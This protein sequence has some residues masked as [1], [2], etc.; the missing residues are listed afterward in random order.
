M[1][2]SINKN[3]SKAAQYEELIK[4]A[5]LLIDPKIPQEGNLANM[6]AL[7]HFHFNFWWTGFYWVKDDILCLGLFQGPSA[8]TQIFKG[9]GVCG[10]A[11][12]QAQT[13]IVEDVNLFEGHIAC[14][15]ASQSEIVVPIVKNGEVIG[16]FDIDSEKKATFDKEDQFYLE[17]LVH[18]V[19]LPIL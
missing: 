10:T 2:I 5:Q 13:I 6:V 3:Q 15:S 4:A 7:L 14:S 16:V 12:Q 9:R 8:C 17:K 19:I 18:E 11:W 1:E